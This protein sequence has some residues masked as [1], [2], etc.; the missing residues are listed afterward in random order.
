MSLGN[1]T[2]SDL[3]PFDPDTAEQHQTHR[4]IQL[5]K[6]TGIN[7]W[8]L[9]AYLV[10]RCVAFTLLAATLVENVCLLPVWGITVLWYFMLDGCELFFLPIKTTTSLLL[11]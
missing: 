4:C 7:V 6:S 10:N 2:S 11:K 5:L 8:V 3:L 1:A 9:A